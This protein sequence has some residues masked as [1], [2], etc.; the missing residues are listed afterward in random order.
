MTY[1]TKA[2]IIWTENGCW[3]QQK[4][5]GLLRSSYLGHIGSPDEVREFCASKAIEFATKY[6][7]IFGTAVAEK[8]PHD[9]R[10]R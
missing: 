2:V 8:W 4:A 7:A 5:D 9:L 3:F 1:P 6:D 10:P